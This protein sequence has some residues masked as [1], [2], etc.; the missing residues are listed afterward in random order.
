MRGKGCKHVRKINP[1]GGRC[2]WDEWVDD[3]CDREER[4]HAVALSVRVVQR[5]GRNTTQ[6][7]C[8]LIPWQRSYM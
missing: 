4:V 1:K 8:Y 3:A 7:W 2:M 6:P 5:L